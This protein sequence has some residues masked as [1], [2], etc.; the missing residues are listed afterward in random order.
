MK[1]KKEKEKQ[2]ALL[3]EDPGHIIGQMVQSTARPQ[4]PM[5]VDEGTEEVPELKKQVA[6][7]KSALAKMRPK[8]EAAPGASQGYNKKAGKGKAT[9]AK[10][11]GKSKG[12]GNAT[13]QGKG[14]GYSSNRWPTCSNKG[15][16]GKGQA[17]SRS[18]W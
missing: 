7:L 6:A 13:Q 1:S 14:K 9:K 18:G 16:K 12:K 4:T 10:G 11:K 17:G 3:A 5:D 15:W 8:N 2:E